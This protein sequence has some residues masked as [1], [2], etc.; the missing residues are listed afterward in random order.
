MDNFLKQMGMRIAA[1]RKELGLTQ[2]ELANVVNVSIQTIS[3]AECG[4]K[5]LRP[6]NIAKISIALNCTTDYLLLGKISLA[7]IE[8]L[9]RTRKNLTPLQYQCLNRII[10]NY[11]VALSSEP[12]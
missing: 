4:K 9:T 3:T 10:E 2:E 6:E 1:R 8:E 5:A 7:P 11:L 12:S